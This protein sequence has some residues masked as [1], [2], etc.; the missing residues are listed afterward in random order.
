MI[1]GLFEQP[2]YVATKSL[3]DATVMRHEAIAANLANLET[4]QYKRIDLDPAFTRELS[5]AIRGGQ[6]RQTA[7][8][9]PRLA[10]DAQAVAQNRDGNTVQLE[11]ELVRLGENQVAHAMETQL[12]SGSL[13]RLR[14][15]I[16]GRV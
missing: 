7:A 16:T 9:K 15:A 6:V 10:I 13:L 3:L 12:I 4:P 5:Q 8:F 2:N 14:L 1:T 11:N